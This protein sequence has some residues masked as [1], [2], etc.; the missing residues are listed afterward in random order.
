MR[1]A[2]AAIKNSLTRRNSGEYCLGISRSSQTSDDPEPNPGRFN[3]AS[4]TVVTLR[5]SIEWP[6]ALDTGGILMTSLDVDD[7][8]V[9]ATEAMNWGTGLAAAAPSDWV[10]INTFAR[11]T[12]FIVSTVHGH[13][14]W[15]DIRR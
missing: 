4:V 12:R 1:K 9:N 13:D 7:E 8:G 11:V 6:E 15:V 3:N 2:K 5:D 14:G 10:A